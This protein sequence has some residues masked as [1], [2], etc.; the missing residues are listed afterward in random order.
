[1]SGWIHEDLISE[2]TPPEALL[3]TY[4]AMVSGIQF[5][6]QHA[7]LQQILF[8]GACGNHGRITKYPQH[9]KSPEKNYEWLLYQFLMRRLGDGKIKFLIPQGYFTRLT[10]YGREIRV[11]HG[12]KIRYQGGVGGIHIPLRKAIAQWNKARHA[13]L[14]ILGHWHT[15]E[16][17]RSYVMNGSLIG[18]NEFAQAIKA[19]YEKPSQS[20][21]LIHPKYG[22]TA[23]F[24]IVLD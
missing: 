13:D 12:D 1:M 7:G 19:D 2:T 10:V 16:V 11:H 9:K 8:V 5:L 3:H 4:E 20:F 23:E 17:S 15:R 21:F 24:P 6:L 18:Y 14:D 22:K